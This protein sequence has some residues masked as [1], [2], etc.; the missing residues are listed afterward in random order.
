MELKEI[1]KIIKDNFKII[2][3]F[4]ALGGLIAAGV[5]A[6]RP[7]EYRGDFVIFLNKAAPPKEFAQSYNDFYALQSLSQVADF[8]VEWA[9]KF[10]ADRPEFELKL[11]KK[12]TLFL[13]GSLTS[14]DAAETRRF[15]DEFVNSATQ[16]IVYFNERIF[17]ESFI[18]ISFSDFKI[19]EIKTNLWRYFGAGIFGGLILGIFA[20][21][22]RHY[23]KN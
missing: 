18:D 12:T 14:R 1:I 10:D 4:M 9:K 21:F 16:H 8:L 11:K 2:A 15:F 17:S 3:V 20:A 19:T 23:F 22:L 6:S 13:E 7:V 5:V